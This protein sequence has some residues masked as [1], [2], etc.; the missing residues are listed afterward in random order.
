MGARLTSMLGYR[1][2]DSFYLTCMNELGNPKALHKEIDFHEE[3]LEHIFDYCT[4]EDTLQYARSSHC[5][6]LQACRFGDPQDQSDHPAGLSD[7]TEP[8][9]L[10]G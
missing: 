1:P 5:C 10:W 6:W 4:P 3:A 2:A 8:G 7:L 9:H